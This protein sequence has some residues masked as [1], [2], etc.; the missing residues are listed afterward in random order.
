MPIDMHDRDKT[1][2]Q[3]FIDAGASGAALQNLDDGG[4]HAKLDGKLLY[5]ACPLR[6]FFKSS[7][8]IST[9]AKYG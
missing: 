2:A 9:L 6:R 7:I 3:P 4:C 5:N 8:I 1:V